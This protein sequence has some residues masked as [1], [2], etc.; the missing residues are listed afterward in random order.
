M[1]TVALYRPFGVELGD[2]R[3]HME[4]FFDYPLGGL[5]GEK[6]PLVDVRENENSYLIEAELPGFDEKD[7]QV[8]VDKG[9]L[10]IESVSEEKKDQDE[11]NFLIRERSKISF[12]RSFQLPDNA[13]A[14]QISAVF[15]NGVLSL[16]VKKLEEAAGRRMI[17]I[18]A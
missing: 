7:I 2:F 14:E 17:Q 3:R 4:D 6:A 10:T 9:T 1:K 5:T 12:C 11:K 18:N 15:K 13:D 8:H 16:E